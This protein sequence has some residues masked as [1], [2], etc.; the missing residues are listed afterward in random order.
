M[1]KQKNNIIMRSTRGMVGKQI[2]FKRRFG[3]GYVAAPPEV[4]ENR[5]PTANQ[6]AAQQKFKKSSAFAKLAM[7]EPLLKEAYK[8]VAKRGQTAFNMA[9]NDAYFAPE[10]VGIITSGYTGAVGSV[11][12][13]Q[14]KD[15]F[16][17]NVV[18]VIIMNAADVVIEEGP[19]TQTP[20]GYNWSYIA[21]VAIA[22]IAGHK[23][24]AVAIDGPENEGIFQVVL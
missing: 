21:T 5:I 19:A 9:F 17:V 10:V 1:A 18:K 16:K 12:L 8:A 23:V 24:K 4:N 14:A 3:K 20:D 22:N 13:V 2:V 7:Q 11:I 15:D 6:L